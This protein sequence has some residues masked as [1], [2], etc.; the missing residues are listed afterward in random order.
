MAAPPQ[1][2]LQQP[3]GRQIELVASGEAG[4]RRPLP[5]SFLGLGQPIL[6][7]IV[8]QR[9]KPLGDDGAAVAG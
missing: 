9:G 1:Q 3:G 6:G 8:E 2:M 7:E 4:D 5:V